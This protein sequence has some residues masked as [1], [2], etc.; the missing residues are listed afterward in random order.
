MLNPRLL[1][2]LSDPPDGEAA[3]AIMLDALAAAARPYDLRFALPSGCAP[4]V[5]DAVLPEKALDPGDVKYYDEAAGLGGVPQLIGDETHFLLLQGSVFFADHWDAALFS[6]YARIPSRRAIL[7]A[8]IRGEGEEAQAY[9]P[10][11]RGTP[12]ADAAPLGPGLPLVNSAAPVR[13]LLIHPALVFGGVAFLRDATLEP[14]LLSI[15]AFAA[16]YAVYALDRAPLWPEGG[17]Q[18][19]ARLAAPPQDLFPQTGLARFEQLAG[20]SFADRAAS[21]RTILGLFGVG[22]TYPQRLPYK[23]ELARRI[24]ERVRPTAPPPLMVSAF[25]D[26]PGSAHPVASYL[27]R[28]SFLQALAR[29]PLTVYTGG[30]AE[31]RLRAAFPNTHAYPDNALLPRALFAD[32]MTPRQLFRRNKL[33]LLEHAGRSYPSYP[34]VAWVDIDALPHPVYPKA[35]PDFSALMDGRVHIGWVDGHPDTSLM[36]VPAGLLRPLAREVRATTQLDVATKGSLSERRLFHRL[37]TLFPDKFALHPLP[38]KGLLFLSCFPEDLLSLP[39]RKLI[40]D[41]PPPVQT[42]PAPYESEEDASDD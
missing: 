9:L 42:P 18:P 5:A 35:A 6:R 37:M 14:S 19:A 22:D 39:L 2:I 31:R 24:R 41:L 3:L 36:V 15:A 38:R 11:V 23:A 34:Y 8:A 16:E 25:I 33:P 10:A 1:V 20:I 13:T 27:I 29:L 12:D 7:T 30:E 28:F 32:G 17:E 26:L 4:A 21:V 40:R